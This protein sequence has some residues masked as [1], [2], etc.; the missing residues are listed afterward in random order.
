MSKV[1]VLKYYYNDYDQLDSYTIAIWKGK[2]DFHK[3]KEWFKQEV[4]YTEGSAES[5]ARCFRKT[6]TS[7]DAVYGMLARGEKVSEF[8]S[9]GDMLEVVEEVLF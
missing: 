6:D 4:D 9:G 1:Y 5:Y 7:E 3:I 2:P 8:D